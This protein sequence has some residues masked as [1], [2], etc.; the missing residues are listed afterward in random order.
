MRLTRWRKRRPVVAVIRLDG[1][2]STASSMRTS[3]LND[4]GLATAIKRAFTKGNPKAVALAVNSPGGSPAQSS[5]I[6]ARIRSMAEE[7]NLPVYAF[8]EDAAASGG[9]WLALAADQI[10]VD[11]C[12][13]IG[14]IGVI[15]ASFGLDRAIERIGIERRLYTSGKEK[16]MLDPFLPQNPNDV[17]RLRGIQNQLHDTFISF[18]KL[19]R[20]SRLKDEEGK[21]EILFTGRFWIGNE[22]VELGLVDGLAHL[23]PKMKEMF[24][25]NVRLREYGRRR[26]FLSGFGLTLA[27]SIMG[28]VEE[29][30]FWSRLGL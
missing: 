29:R 25:S 5:L 14:S 28:L 24:G 12:S 21:T 18:V 27:R 2:I 19:R 8:V 1:V 15:S 13:I 11:D 7:K 6:A 10:F 20:G 26:R 22:A 4:A 17:E 3:G 9:Y 16:S 23:E 30:A